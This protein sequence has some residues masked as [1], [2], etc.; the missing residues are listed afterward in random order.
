[1][2]LKLNTKRMNAF[3]NIDKPFETII[4]KIETEI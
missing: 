3:H 1:M 4:D 2:D